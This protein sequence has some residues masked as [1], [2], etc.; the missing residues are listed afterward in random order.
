MNIETITTGII[1]DY[2]MPLERMI[3]AGNYDWK[4]SN[5]TA[6]KFLVEGSDIV[7]FE[8]EVFR[9]DRYI[10]SDAAVEAIKADDRHNPWE[11][12]KIEGLLAYEA[13]NPEEQRKYP[14][15]ALGSVA[16]VRGFRYVPGL[17]RN[18]AKRGLDLRWWGDAWFGGCRFLGVRKLP[19]AA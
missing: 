2:G 1:V 12:A 5:I 17:S 19:S 18:G 8:S 4:N 9:F 7:Q 6:A 13:K 16:R 10:S 11:P 15:I 3:A 14:I